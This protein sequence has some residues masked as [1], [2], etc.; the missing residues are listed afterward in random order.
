MRRAR[1]FRALN[2]FVTGKDA[3]YRSGSPSQGLFQCGERAAVVPG[4]VGA[5]DTPESSEPNGA[6]P[7]E[8]NLPLVAELSPA[9]DNVSS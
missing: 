9:R 1:N 2:G 5:L 6:D 4:S 8:V 7:R 3:V